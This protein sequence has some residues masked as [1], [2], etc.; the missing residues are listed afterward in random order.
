[1]IYIFLSSFLISQI[2]PRDKIVLLHL[3]LLKKEKKARA[4]NLLRKFN[5]TY[6]EVQQKKGEKEETIYV[7]SCRLSK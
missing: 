6:H 7:V 1:M 5:P 4:L 3:Y 2:F